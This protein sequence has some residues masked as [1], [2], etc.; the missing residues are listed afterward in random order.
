MAKPRFG[1]PPNRWA[2][3]SN[4]E[5]DGAMN[6]IFSAK[7][8]RSWPL[9]L[10]FSLLVHAS[11]IIPALLFTANGS[12]GEKRGSS[13]IDTLSTAPATEIRVVLCEPRRQLAAQPPPSPL[14][15][16]SAAPLPSA[17]EQTP[18]GS[19]ARVTAM[20]NNPSEGNSSATPITGSGQGSAT[21]LDT[22]T[23]A[24]FQIGTQAKAIVYVIDR[25]GSMG[26]NGC[27][28]TAKRELRASLERLPSTTRF[29][30]IAYN[31]CAEPLRIDGQSALVFATPENKRRVALLLKDIEAE[32]DTYHLPALKRA[33]GLRP[34]VIFLLTDAAGLRPEQIQAI[35]AQNQGQTV[36]HAIELG[37]AP[38]LQGDL[39]LY[40]LAQQNQGVYKC[41]PL[42]P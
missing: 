22:G 24:F 14:M 3:P 36:I 23:A 39:P 9:A 5:A 29:Q 42:G 7:I 32:G 34:D 4:S 26:L 8:A 41:V 30:I 33:L 38:G 31:R 15:A 40:A 11:M 18:P 35:T 16:K 1:K 19:L 25:S 28:A 6:R 17:E 37:R 20:A 27:L 10:A 2:Y 12:L 13:Q 21:G